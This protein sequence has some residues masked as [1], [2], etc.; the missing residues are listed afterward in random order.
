MS[1]HN[2]QTDT[3]RLGV[4]ISRLEDELVDYKGSPSRL[5]QMQKV[6]QSRVT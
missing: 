6:T 1:I 3:S 4:M 5:T 2:N